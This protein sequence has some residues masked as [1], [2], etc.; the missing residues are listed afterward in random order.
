MRTVRIILTA[1]LLGGSAVSF[2]L[3][4]SGNHILSPDWHPHARF[5]GGL[6][7][8]LLA[9]VSLT[10][11]WL[12]WRKSQEPQIAIAV[13]SLISLSFW[14]PLLYVGSI[15]PGSTP[16]AGPQ[17]R[18]PHVA[19]MV[20]Y[21]NMAVAVLFVLLTLG[22]WWFGSRVPASIPASQSLRR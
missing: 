1:I 17:G 15:V 13:A 18:E 8:F 14:T 19:G 5:H 4:W 9:G 6:L 2:Y 21:P 22:A 11:T 3:D 16:W 20:F 7:L 12:L 10:G